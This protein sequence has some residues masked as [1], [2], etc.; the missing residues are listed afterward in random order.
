MTE[1][2]IPPPEPPFGSELDAEFAPFMRG[3]PSLILFRTAARNPQ[4][5]KRLFAGDLLDK[6]ST[7]IRT[8]V[9]MNPRT[10]ALCGSAYER[11]GNI[12]TFGAKAA[13]SS[14]ETISR[15]AGDA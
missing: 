4:G 6:G 15:A 11:G 2:H 3:A 12:K 10:R 7:A 1:V 8:H 5:V 13:W 9:L 14:S